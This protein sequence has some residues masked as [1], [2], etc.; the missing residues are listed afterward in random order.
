MPKRLLYIV[1][2]FLMACTPSQDW[3]EGGIY[4]IPGDDGTFQALKILKL[5]DDGVHLRLYSNTYDSIPQSIDT[6]ALYMAG[7]DREANEP[8]GMGHA[9]ISKETFSHWGAIYIQEST[10][11]EDEL[12]G[13]EM[14]KEGG[15]GYF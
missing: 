6:S 5:D 4:V 10:V 9:P 1:F 13:Y 11:S 14:W 2:L 15:G 8:L 12:D 7:I 3:I